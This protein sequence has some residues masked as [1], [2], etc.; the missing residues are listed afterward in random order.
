MTNG[1]SEFDPTGFFVLRA[2]ALP[3]DTIQQLNQ[4]S[5]AQENGEA[6]S[7][8]EDQP[9]RPGTDVL[10]GYFE[11]P[12][13]REALYIASSSL[14]ETLDAWYRD[15]AS[16]ELDLRARRS[17]IRYLFRM[18][19]RP[20][21]Y[22]LFAG[23]SWGTLGNITRLELAGRHAL[24][25]RTRIDGDYVRALLER[26]VDDDHSW[27]GLAYKP[28]PSG[29][30]LGDRFVY[31]ETR[32][33]TRLATYAELTPELDAVLRE[34]SSGAR[35]DK[36][37]AT[38]SKEGAS[39]EEAEAF[40]RELVRAQVLSPT[41]ELAG[42]GPDFLRQLIDGLR[43]EP[44]LAQY[45]SGL[46]EV[47]AAV[48]ASGAAFVP[49]EFPYHAVSRRLKGLALAEPPGAPN[50]FHVDLIHTP[51]VM[52]LGNDVLD[53]I[54]DGVEMLTSVGAVPRQP[55]LT[56][57]ADAFVERY[58][59]ERL[60][61]LV[62][63]FDSQTGLDLGGRGWRGV[64]P[65]PLVDDLELSS[66]SSQE[67][68]YWG[69]RDIFL[70][71]LLSMNGDSRVLDLRHG[72]MAA[73][74]FPSPAPLPAAFSVLATVTAGEA[75]TVQNGASLQVWLKALAGPSGLQLLGRFGGLDPELQR[76]LKH[77]AAREERHDPQS[78]Y[79]EVSFL[80]SGRMMNVVSHPPLRAWE[81]PVASGS[82]LPSHRQLP[83]ADLFVT[84]TKGRVSLYSKRLGRRIIP[85]LSSAHNVNRSDSS[86]YRFLSALQTHGAEVA[87][88]WDWGMLTHAYFLP[89][90]TAG[91]A[92]LAPA[93]W[94]LT[95]QQEARVRDATSE[96]ELHELIT[97][98]RENLNW[99]RY[100]SVGPGD[101]RLVVDL[102]NRRS[103][104]AAFSDARLWTE[105]PIQES[106]LDPGPPYVTSP[107]GRFAHELVI[108]FVRSRPDAFRPARAPSFRRGPAQ[109]F[110]PGSEWLYAKIYTGQSAADTI[111]R[112]VIADTGGA[113]AFGTMSDR[114]FFLRYFDSGF[115][116]RVRF[117]GN[118]A[119][120]CGTLL[121]ALRSRLYARQDLWWRFQLDQYHP[122]VERYGGWQ[123]LCCAEEVFT[124]DS[125]FTLAVLR[126]ERGRLGPPEDRWKVAMCSID[127]L[128][129]DFDFSL[130]EK[131]QFAAARHQQLA[132]QL[133]A[134]REHFDEIGRR[135]RTYKTIVSES[136]SSE[137]TSEPDVDRALTSRSRVIASVAK[138]LR[139]L[140]DK[141][142]LCVPLPVLMGSYVHMHVNRLIRSQQ[143]DHEFVM[144]GFLARF[145]R[146]LKAR[147]AA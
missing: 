55:V 28:N 144:L 23:V 129:D 146:S 3:F 56:Q 125:Y 45:R 80:P 121:P 87:P 113:G 135:Y 75:D 4:D 88:V 118:P 69:E 94:R 8:G 49:G 92:I 79:A 35:V 67:P 58:G 6:N 66:G 5:R 2:P 77:H 44:A 18:A 43:E 101:R 97:D 120:L 111:L 131:L 132:S 53:V 33:G 42:S 41:I 96:E 123:G 81:I 60:V 91:R 117:R 122:E 20:T 136:L 59:A 1:L 103:V 82:T 137:K 105:S 108:P 63:I 73:L 46:G 110:A 85:R 12:L 100:I 90:V 109:S 141:R 40:A 30:R 89:R 76:W 86:I 84:V 78:I 140:D 126:T 11:D 74:T 64:T 9:E 36:I 61:S 133:G 52:L 65:A 93:Q 16:K 38:L 119:R 127:R 142:E 104:D 10:R 106:L 128:L 98:I 71:R 15:G 99:P 47:A 83:V 130:D 114:F 14:Y 72:S 50:L 139:T 32:R 29:Y 34:T 26:I 37:V 17:F 112:E 19:S 13:V 51:K 24:R 39:E 27:R 115:H 102:V 134:K 145:Y 95:P 68:E 7:Y 25:R 31:V 107:D 62:E 21:P 116:L 48:G 138:T 143:P 147:G 22:G 70:V 124:A 54:R 57:F